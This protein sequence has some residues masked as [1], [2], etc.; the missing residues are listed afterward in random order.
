LLAISDARARR[1]LPHA[2]NSTFPA[3]VLAQPV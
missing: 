2:R 3:L 1:A